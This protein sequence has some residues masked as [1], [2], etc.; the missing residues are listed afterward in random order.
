VS[1]A[2]PGSVKARAKQNRMM[3]I[4]RFKCCRSIRIGARNKNNFQ[5][6]LAGKAGWVRFLMPLRTGAPFFLLKDGP[7]VGDS[8]TVCTPARFLLE[9]SSRLKIFLHRHRR[10]SV[11]KIFLPPKIQ[12]AAAS[13]IYG[14]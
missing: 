6:P 14:P 12:T 4:R 9:A 7:R 1:A 10:N 11:A 2:R 8:S 13:A 3:W 5:K